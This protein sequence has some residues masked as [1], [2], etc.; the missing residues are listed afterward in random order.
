MLVQNWTAGSRLASHRDS[1]LESVSSGVV[2]KNFAL[3][4]R[5][6]PAFLAWLLSPETLKSCTED[7]GFGFA[8]DFSSRTKNRCP[9][10]WTMPELGGVVG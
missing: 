2:P 6:G 1:G 8:L 10:M 4:T 5:A 7:H 3:A 9:S